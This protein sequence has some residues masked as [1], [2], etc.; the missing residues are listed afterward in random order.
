LHVTLK[1][2]RDVS[3]QVYRQLRDAILAGH[4][5]AAEALPSSR[6]FAGQIG[7]SRNTVLLVYDRLRSEG[8]VTS[9]VGAGTFVSEGIRPR[10]PIGPTAS[11]LRPRAI[12]DEIPDGPDLSDPRPEFD[13]RPGI[14]DVTGFP[15]AAWRSRISRQF[16]PSAVGS[17]API[18][19]A[20]HP[21]L[22]AAIARHVGVARAVRATADD[23]VVTNGTQQAL[24]LIA[25]V[26][27]A[28]GDAVAVE[29][30]GYPL[31][32]RVFHAY[33][34]RVVGVPVDADGMIVDAIPRGVRLAYVTPSHQYPLGMAMSMVRRQAL[35]AWARRTDATIV[36]DD[37]DSEFRFGARSLEPL[38]SLDGS[39]RV[40]YVGSF[41]K[42]IFSTLRLGFLIAPRSLRS[43]LC[44]AKSVSDWH[45]AVPLQAAAALFMDDGLLA[46]HIRRMRRV[47]A[48]RHELVQEILRRQF[49]DRLTPLPTV[50]GLHLAALLRRRR[51]AVDLA[52]AESA[53]R[54]GVAVLPL[55]Y[56]YLSRRRRP[57][58]LIG[59][60]AIATDRIEEGLRRFR[61][62]L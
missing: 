25:R 28:P 30:P 48:D 18:G 26:M 3:G 23:V 32:R 37:Y 55:S 33:G 8:F 58:F 54:L 13:L 7:V 44:R 19:A 50:G 14:P 21:G 1:G 15:F 27:L 4:L 38:Q 47:Y 17:G 20:G 46:Q 6:E 24:D 60:G 61:R 49:G 53:W 22:R 31:A 59:Y 34:C 35:L 42:V 11:P 5:H 29:D 16:Y 45:S 9:R 52:I 40:I 12:W 10:P 43:A 56:H 36:E 57:G 41:S 2:R 62:C 39:G 51:G